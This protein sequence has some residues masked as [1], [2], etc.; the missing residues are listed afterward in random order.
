[1]S[2][3]LV[4]KPAAEDDLFHAYTWYEGKQ[5]GLGTVFLESVESVFERIVG[6]PSLYQEVEASIRRGVT[7]TF[8]YCVF[9]TIDDPDVAVIAV[10]DAAQ[11][12]QYIKS[13]WNV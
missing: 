2:Y 13:R 7:R 8:P 3:R 1:M 10:I 11:D 6:N 12:P 5:R 9:Y 4:V